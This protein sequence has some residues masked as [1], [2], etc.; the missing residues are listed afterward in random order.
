MFKYIVPVLF[1]LVSSNLY[2]AGTNTPAE[3][4]RN[5][6]IYSE[7][8]STYVDLIASGCSGYRYYLPSN[9]VK[10]NTIV[11]VILAAQMSNRNVQIKFDGC[12]SNNQGR[13]T[14]VYL[15]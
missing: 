3:V 14:G 15:K 10:Y 9:H 8:G 7:S 4:P 13:I 5:F 6:H 2:A 12:N 1:M 11:S